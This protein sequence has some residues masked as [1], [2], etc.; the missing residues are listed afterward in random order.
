[1]MNMN[2]PLVEA[3]K[4]AMQF[5]DGRDDW[6]PMSREE[7]DRFKEL[8]GRVF[9]LTVEAGLESALPQ[10]ANLERQ[11]H[12]P[13]LPPVQFEGK[14]NLPGDWNFLT[15]KFEPVQT[16][17]GRWAEDMEWLLHL[18]EQ[19]PDDPEA[20]N[21]EDAG[22]PL[23]ARSERPKKLL[24]GWHEITVALEMT[25]GNREKIKSL[26][27]RFDGPIVNQGSGSQPMV[28][29]EELIEWWNRLATLQQESANQSKGR[30][31]TAEAQ[32]N[33]GREG[34][35]A[36]EIGGSIKKRRRPP[37]RS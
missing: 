27:E 23:P 11:C 18:A 1:M 20:G 28:Y 34:T 31:L 36:P 4:A 32:H 3:I 8:S 7:V 2:A 26:N 16:S 9:I 6:N 30:K 25:H 22:G 29:R 37:K 24:T 35:A 17:R 12:D 5:V 33:Y 15:G 19:T 21:R 13:D 14:L 10:T